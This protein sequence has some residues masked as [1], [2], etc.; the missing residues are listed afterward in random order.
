MLG[1]NYDLKNSHVLLALISK[2]SDAVSRD[3]NFVEC[4]GVVVF[5]ENLCM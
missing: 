1:D 2:F 4:W 5:I 3:L